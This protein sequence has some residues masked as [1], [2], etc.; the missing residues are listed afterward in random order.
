MS[1]LD[2]INH[3]SA[4]VSHVRDNKVF[5]VRQDNGETMLLNLP[6]IGIDPIDV[7]VGDRVMLTI[8]KNSRVQ[9]IE[10]M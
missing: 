7:R 1:M 2:G 5:E 4:V 9:N 8:T 3:V 6:G 10:R